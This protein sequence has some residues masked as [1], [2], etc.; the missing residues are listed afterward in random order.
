[1]HAHETCTCKFVIFRS[2][3]IHSLT[4]LCCHYSARDKVFQWVFLTLI[5]VWIQ[6]VTAHIRSTETKETSLTC[7]LHS[8]SSVCPACQAAVPALWVQFPCC[9]MTRLGIID[10]SKSIASTSISWPH[11]VGCHLCVL[12]CVCVCVLVYVCACA[13]PVRSHLGSPSA[14]TRWP[15]SGSCHLTHSMGPV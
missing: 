10:L 13:Y 8:C 7:P 5:M 9:Q 14:H 4:L 15:P 6:G 3:N 2:E 12:V 11:S 1:M